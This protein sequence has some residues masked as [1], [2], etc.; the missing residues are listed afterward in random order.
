MITVLR[1]SLLEL[2]A[3]SL[4]TDLMASFALPVMMGIDGVILWAGGYLGRTAQ[5]CKAT[6]HYVDALLGPLVQDIQK[7]R[8]A[9]RDYFCL[10]NTFNNSSCFDTNKLCSWSLPMDAPGE[11]HLFMKKFLSVACRHN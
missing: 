10:P 8:N 5:Q 11:C 6:A 4:Q 9:C 1:I 7:L 3:A 2:Y